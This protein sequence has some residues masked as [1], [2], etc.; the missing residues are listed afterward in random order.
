MYKSK[1]LKGFLTRN[2][3][4]RPRADFSTSGSTLDFIFCSSLCKHVNSYHVYE[5]GSFSCTSDHLPVAINIDIHVKN[6]I[7]HKSFNSLPACH[8]AESCKLEQYQKHVSR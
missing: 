2:N 7:L 3:I 1:L 8:K 4:G 5:E 6:C